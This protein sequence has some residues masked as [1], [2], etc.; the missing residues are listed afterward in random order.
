M[1]LN[2]DDPP[3]RGILS[4][5]FVEAEYDANYVDAARPQTYCIVWVLE[6]IKWRRRK[7]QPAAGL[8]PAWGAAFDFDEVRDDSKVVVDVWC[9]GELAGAHDEFFGKVTLRIDELLRKPA[10]AWHELVPGRRRGNQ[11]RSCLRLVLEELQPTTGKRVVRVRNAA[12]SRV[13]RR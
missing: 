10:G 13:S 3:A 5:E 7:S 6:K 2:F 8:R 11:W 12:E 9:K 1:R 4:V